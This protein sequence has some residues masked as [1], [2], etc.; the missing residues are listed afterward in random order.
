MIDY[1]FKID[2]I[3]IID[4]TIGLKILQVI[5]KL[6]HMSS[7]AILRQT[8]IRTLSLVRRV[9]VILLDKSH[10]RKTRDKCIP[11]RLEMLRCDL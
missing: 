3:L 6:S 4:Q 7:L 8:L 11:H 9:F 10:I 1:I 5:L 2:N